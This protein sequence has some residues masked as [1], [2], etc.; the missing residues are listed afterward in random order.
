MPKIAI[1]YELLLDEA[2]KNKGLINNCYYIC[3]HLLYGPQELRII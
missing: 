2:W 1:K 3:T